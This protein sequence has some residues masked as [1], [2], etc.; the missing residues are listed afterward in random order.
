MPLIDYKLEV[1][2]RAHDLTKPE[3][4]L[5]YVGDA[6]K[7]VRSA[8]TAAEREMMLK[9]LRDETGISFE[10]LS[11]DLQQVPAERQEKG[12][13][14]PKKAADT[15]DVMMKASRFRRGG[16]IFSARATRRTRT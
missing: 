12:G 7:V 5:K 9:N 10:A 1:A 14:S 2:R 4:K 11:R 15:A 16:D 6:L 3:E 8:E 13:R